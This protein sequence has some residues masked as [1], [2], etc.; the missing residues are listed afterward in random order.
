MVARGV[1]KVAVCLTVAAAAIAELG[2][3]GVDGKVTVVEAFYACGDGDASAD[4]PQC[5][6]TTVEGLG[7]CLEKVGDSCPGLRD[8]LHFFAKLEPEVDLECAT[9]KVFALKKELEKELEDAAVDTSNLWLA[10]GGL[11]TGFKAPDDA[12][13]RWPTLH[14]K[15]TADCATP[16]ATE[17]FKTARDPQTM[18]L[19]MDPNQ[20]SEMWPALDAAVQLA[21]ATCIFVPS[22]TPPVLEV[23][24]AFLINGAFAS[25]SGSSV[26][27]LLSFVG[28]TLILTN[29]FA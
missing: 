1:C 18:N 5:S 23:F 17:G 20:F 6:A 27:T 22:S 8:A 14:S 10:Y 26:F 28:L 11:D 25:L 24:G 12:A 3:L 7:E 21:P 29:I 16:A 2:R 19:I 4:P 13:C 9:G 15:V